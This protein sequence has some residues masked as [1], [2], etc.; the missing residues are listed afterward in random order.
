ME[1]GDDAFDEQVWL[2][3][4]TILLQEAKVL[5]AL[6]YDFEIPCIVQWG[7]PWFSA[8]T[9]VNNEFLTHGVI[10]EKI[11]RQSIWLPKVFSLCLSG[12]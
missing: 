9:S 10:F 4:R 8:P 11:M 3:A 2:S 5:E 7:M 1:C 6:Q 12:A